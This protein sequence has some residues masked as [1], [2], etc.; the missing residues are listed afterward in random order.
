MSQNDKL[1]SE[2]DYVNMK[3]L[4]SLA[5]ENI[6][7]NNNDKSNHVSKSKEFTNSMIFVTV[8]CIVIAFIELLSRSLLDDLGNIIV[9]KVIPGPKNCNLLNT[10]AGFNNFSVFIFLLICIFNLFNLYCTFIWVGLLTLG[11]FISGVL[12]LIYQSPRPFMINNSLEPCSCKTSYANPSENA[13]S[14]LLMIMG[15]Y[16]IILFRN[17]NIYLKYLFQAFCLLVVVSSSL[18]EL[19]RNTESLSQLLYGLIVG[20]VI[21]HF[22]FNVLKVN[23]EK[24]EQLVIL[25]D[26]NYG[27]KLGVIFTLLALII[28]TSHYLLRDIIFIE[29]Q[30]WLDNTMLFCVD[31]NLDLDT[32]FLLCYYVLSLG[33]FFSIYLEYIYIFD[34]N[35][36]QFSLYNLEQYNR[37]NQTAFSL[38]LLRICITFI[39]FKLLNNVFS[40]YFQFENMTITL[41]VFIILLLFWG[42]FIFT[43]SKNVLRFI[44]LTNES[45]IQDYIS[46]DNSRESDTLY[47]TKLKKSDIDLY[48]QDHFVRGESILLSPRERDINK[49]KGDEIDYFNLERDAIEDYQINRE[50]QTPPTLNGING[51]HGYR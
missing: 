46:L 40:N 38:Q 10:L 51:I 11:K 26:D 18:F 37:W 16:R 48:K 6:N 50:F 36:I 34:S 29:D 41:I 39:L 42:F 27:L 8:L 21:Y 15:L 35:K 24:S 22:Y 49:K 44:F 45:V 32:Y 4:D 2:V 23:P 17:I 7:N 12:L 31:F 20:G 47:D 43:I 25:F 13:T 33:I 3:T 30:S 9:K 19:M 1:T 5:A 14:I 28:N